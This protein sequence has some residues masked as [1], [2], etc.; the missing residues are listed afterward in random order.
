MNESFLQYL[1]QFQYFQKDQLE[2]TEKEKIVVIRTGNYNNDAGP[3]FCNARVKIGEIEWL[4]HVEIHTRS[5][6]WNT[7]KHQ[8]D[9]AYDNVILHVVWEFDKSIQRQDGSSI[10]TLVLKGRVK[11][12]LISEYKKL[13]GSGH[14]V[15][16]QNSLARVPA[17]VKL[18]ALE[19]ALLRRLEV[20]ANFIRDLL[21]QNSGDW[22]ETAYQVLAKNFGFKINSDSF[23]TLATV[24]PYKILRKHANQLLQIE[25]L[26]FGQAGMLAPS[27]KDDYAASLFQEFTFLK[28]KY[29]LK[30]SLLHAS[31]WKFLRLRP[32]NFPT[33]RLAQF[34][35]LLSSGNGIFSR[36]MAVTKYSELETWFRFQTSPYWQTHYRFGKKA[37]K[38]VP[39]LG[40]SSIQN[41]IIN[42][43]VPLLVAYGKAKDDQECIDRA[44]EILQHVPRES[45]RIITGW[46]ELGYPV[47]SSFDSQAL[48]ELFNNSCQKR[49]CLNCPIG[50]FLLKPDKE[51]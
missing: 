13:I 49:N 12:N 10:P 34:A 5:S 9:K 25:A 21:E 40:K 18:D 48:I 14:A 47:K 17:I 43:L 24:T 36:L 39:P 4:G 20:K 22:E 27:T 50:I 23:L 46:E 2:T 45:N 1:W 44:L 33:V 26:L 41:I 28:H 8:H 30:D 19:K 35:A 7:H 29:S 16:C 51:K 38:E 3:D 42:S 31:Q 32:S 37:A 6:E 15:P 11:E